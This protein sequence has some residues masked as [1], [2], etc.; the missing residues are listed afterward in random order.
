L[1]LTSRTFWFKQLHRWHWIS[2]AVC[3]C[4]MLLFATTGITLNHAAQI[5]SRPAVMEKRGLLPRD[6]LDLLEEN[7]GDSKARLP[8]KVS[9]WLEQH[10]SVSIAER[11]AEWSADEIYVALPVP[12]GDEWLSIDRATG[13]V[14]YERTDNGLISYLNDLHKGRNTGPAW[15]WFL[16]IFAAGCVIFSL[17]GL[18]LLQLNSRMRPATWPLVTLGLAIPL[19]LVM[20]LAH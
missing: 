6:L 9:A 17:T 18:V 4:G 8:E 20:L 16:D 1:K 3:L 11:A 13:E 19:V 2:A 5:E 10:L 15:N 7:T 12:G 14:I